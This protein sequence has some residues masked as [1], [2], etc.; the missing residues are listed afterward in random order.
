MQKNIK[1]CLFLV[2]LSVLCLLL[3][4]VIWGQF[5]DN[6]G[7]DFIIAF[8]PNYNN[9][10]HNV[11]LH[12]TG[13][14]ATNV[15]IQYPINSPTF[16][17]TVAVTPGLITIVS[18]PSTA[19]SSWTAGSSQNNCVHAFAEDEFVCYMVNRD[20]ATSDAALALPVETMNTEY[21]VTTYAGGYGLGSE[22]VVVA[23]YDDTEVTIDPL[24]GSAYSVLLKRGE[25]YMVNSDSDLTGTIVTA[26]RPI[27]MTNGNLCVAYDG[28][29]CDH[30]FEVAMPVQTWGTM[31]PV[32][33]LPE[34]SQGVRY[35]ILASE[36]NTDVTMDGISQGIINRGQF[37][38]TDR[39]A[40]N[41]IIEGSNPIF[42]V[43]FMANR[44]SSGGHPV[45]DPAMGNMIPA[46]QYMSDYTFSTVGGSQ[47][48][49]NNLT[50]IAESAD[51]NTIQ[52]DGSPIGAAN[53]TQIGTSDY[54][55][56][57][58]YLANG[59][60]TTSSNGFHAI[61]VEG[62]NRHDSYLYPG[63]ALF[64]FINPV[65][66]ENPPECS[67]DFVD[68]TGTCTAS[69]E[70]PTEDING[71]G[72]LD[73]GEDLNGNGII[74]KDTGVFFVDLV[75]G[76]MNLELTVDPFVPG[77]GTVN[78]TVSL[79]DPENDGSGVIRVT[80][81]AGNTCETDVSLKEET[82]LI[83]KSMTPTYD[84]LWPV[85]AHVV[86]ENAGVAPQDDVVVH[87]IAAVCGDEHLVGSW[88]GDLPLGETTLDFDFDLTS[89]YSDQ[90][91]VLYAK[92]D[93]ENLISERYETNNEVG[94]I[95]RVGNVTPD[96]L[97]IVSSR[98]F[99][100][101]YCPNAV[102][103][104]SG[105][106][107]YKLIS[108]GVACF[109][110]SVKGGDVT[111]ELVRSSDQSIVA[112][113]NVKTTVSGYWVFSIGLPGD[114]GGVYEL[115]IK[116]TD[117]TLLEEFSSLLSIVDCSDSIT[118]DNPNPVTP[119]PP[120]MPPYIPSPGYSY[121]DSGDP[122]YPSGTYSPIIILGSGGGVSGWDLII[123]S[124]TQIPIYP[125]GPGS[126]DYDPSNPVGPIGPGPD[127]SPDTFDAW[128]YSVD[129][130]F[131][132]DTPDE[133]ETITIKGIVHAN[134]SYFGLPVRW[135]ATYLTAG[136]V[137]IAPTTYYYI[138]GDLP[139]EISFTRY[140]PGDIIIEIELGP[141][142]SDADNSN[143][144]ATRVL[145]GD[146]QIITDLYAREKYGKVQL[147]WTHIGAESYNVY[148][149]T[150]GD[151]Y[152]LIVNTTS[153]YSTY[154]DRN[155][156]SGTTYYYV[157]KSIF[158]GSESLSSNEV[159]ITPRTTRRR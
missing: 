111:Y 54:Y 31:I 144:A 5:L 36:N 47:F 149:R 150:E 81:G 4:G 124:N 116:V 32:A 91:V 59:V 12:L 109:D 136:T 40:G 142:F 79:I 105:T 131:S 10:T 133:G 38:L 140:V 141:D 3:P 114:V 85:S 8:M 96:Q 33:N 41:H 104:F 102:A 132:N 78:Y 87:L 34:T 17:T 73:S 71:N 45:G 27:G 159:I 37:I 121:G 89:I 112:S 129:I 100:T 52:L 152:S 48:I 103:T 62:F 42:V 94:N 6:K 110:Y 1:L 118:P 151:E 82:D 39:V 86:V 23:A 14:V 146:G 98:S 158:S 113:G 2:P 83:A 64:E 50:V 70:R 25:G 76:S 63:G 134:N 119:S 74:D 51:I 99:P 90:A 137:T 55:V 22:F 53:F 29:Y 92:V 7:N 13:D 93:P 122:N 157:V 19:S 44:S 154:L 155:V 15:T 148:R 125:G 107:V 106:S 88:Q 84:L 20:T 153:T 156:I 35:K 101:E 28:S 127:S 43:Q 18:L 145:L 108:E 24:S 95:L 49:E 69:D 67:C 143:N 130:E 60:H 139:V 21:I 138:N 80:D 115:Q 128:V 72:I 65:G 123:P 68:D 56:S 75:D 120:Y 66:D 117:H 57:L 97:A 16:S 135:K 9:Y 30:I 26:D 61:T 58:I 77:G 147:V 46:A 11:E 126:S